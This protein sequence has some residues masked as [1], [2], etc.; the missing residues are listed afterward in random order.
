MSICQ[1]SQYHLMSIAPYVLWVCQCS[2]H[3]LMSISPALTSMCIRSAPLRP[4]RSS[5]CRRI[6]RRRQH[7]GTRPTRSSC[8]DF[9]C[10]DRGRCLVSSGQT[11]C[12]VSL[13]LSLSL[14]LSVCSTS[15]VAA[16]QHSTT[17]LSTSLPTTRDAS[18]HSICLAVRDVVHLR[19]PTLV[20]C[21]QCSACATALSS[22]SFALFATAFA[23]R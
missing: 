17:E 3:H 8:T 1:C 21:G 22:V 18:H 12:C 20:R 6:L 23:M 2:Q 19:V 5:I 15:P 16:P 4:S 11:V 7:I 13:S 10:P 9:R 14:P